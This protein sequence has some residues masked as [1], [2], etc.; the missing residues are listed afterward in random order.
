MTTW[1]PVPPA[2]PLSGPSDELY[3]ALHPVLGDPIDEALVLR[4]VKKL[5]KKRVGPRTAALLAAFPEPKAPANP[6]LALP[7]GPREH[8]M[9]GR[10]EVRRVRANA[11]C[12]ADRQKKRRHLRQREYQLRFGRKDA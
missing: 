10:S 11:P 4:L 3:L 5:R 7:T 6:P 8:Y 9:S 12:H 1:A 2:P